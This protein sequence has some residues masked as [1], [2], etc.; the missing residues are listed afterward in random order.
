MNK[1]KQQLITIGGVVT[2]LLA[3]AIVVWALVFRSPTVATLDGQRIRANDLNFL[4]RQTENVFSQEYFAMFPADYPTINHSRVFRNG[5]TF[6]RVVREEAARQ[7]ALI[8][9]FENFARE[10]DIALTDED[11]AFI[12]VEVD[13]MIA[14]AGGRANFYAQIQFDGLRNRREVEAMFATWDLMDLVIESIIFDPLW[15][16]P[17]AQYMGD[18]PEEELLA[19]KHILSRFADFDGD[20]EAARENAEELLARAIAGENFD[21][22]MHAYSQDPG[23]NDWPDGYTFT[24][25]V[26]DPAFENA[27]RSLAIGGISSLVRTS[28]GYHI[29]LRIQPNPN[30]VMRPWGAPGELEQMAM[31]VIRGFEAQVEAQLEFMPALD[32]LRIR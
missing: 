14:E 27:T 8:V 19:A 10:H 21:M 18:I 20:E 32:N 12:A 7:A 13:H 1:S 16:A 3:V 31:A 22:L 11:L 30:D 5:L 26:M 4:L 28:H 25:G 23:L 24:A 9:A 6:G 15:F 29:V 17:F 2:A